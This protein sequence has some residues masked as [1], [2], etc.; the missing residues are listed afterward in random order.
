MILFFKNTIILSW[1]M[2]LEVR[3]EIEECSFKAGGQAG[4]VQD[5]RRSYGQIQNIYRRTDLGQVST[6][7]FF[8]I[9]IFF[10]PLMFNFSSFFPLTCFA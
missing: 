6:H 1:A 2:A 4:E 9:F 7:Y 3:M 10:L 8:F 5:P